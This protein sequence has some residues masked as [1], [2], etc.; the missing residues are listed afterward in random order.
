MTWLKPHFE[1]LDTNGK[2]ERLGDTRLVFGEKSGD[3]E[4]LTSFPESH[5]N[6]LRG[7]S[8]WFTGTS[9]F[10]RFGVKIVHDKKRAY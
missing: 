3:S 5:M 2:R 10:Q 6:P 7:R 9:D 4:N 1:W 8:Q